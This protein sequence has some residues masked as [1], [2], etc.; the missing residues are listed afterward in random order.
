M[1]KYINQL[2]QLHDLELTLHENKI[3]HKEKHLEKACKELHKDINELKKNLPLEILSIYERISKRYPVPVTPM[4]NST[5]NGCFMKLPVGIAN[6]VY[7]DSQ[8]ICCPN[9]SRFLYFDDSQIKDTNTELHYKGIARFSSPELMMPNIKAASKEAAI[10]KI[11]AHTVKKGF[12]ENHDVFIKALLDREA[13]ASTA[14]EQGIAFP[15]ARGVKACGLTLTVATVRPAIKLEDGGTVSL[16]FASAV[17]RH[18]SMFYLELVSKL[19]QYFGKPEN[20]EKILV[21]ETEKD[22]WNILVQV[23]K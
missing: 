11:A 6:A 23:G 15:H 17:P 7:S 2:L 9:C 1:N 5:C 19:A 3:L 8:W 21:S 10:K 12:V 18:S 20:L 14:V 4:I 22:M 16:F 13:L